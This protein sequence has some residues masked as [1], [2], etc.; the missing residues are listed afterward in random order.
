MLLL[1]QRAKRLFIAEDIMMQIK[2]EARRQRLAVCEG[3]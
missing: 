3:A 2:R 1:L